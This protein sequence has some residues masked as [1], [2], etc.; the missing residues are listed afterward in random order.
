[1]LGLDGGRGHRSS[2]GRISSGPSFRTHDT[3]SATGYASIRL[4]LEEASDDGP[5]QFLQE[6]GPVG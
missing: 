6:A 1:V 3:R 2:A 5:Y 4:A